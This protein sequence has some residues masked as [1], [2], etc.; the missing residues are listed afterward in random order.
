MGL[1][2]IDKIDVL[3]PIYHGCS[4]QVLSKGAGHLPSSALPI[5]SIGGRSLISAHSGSAMA[6]L[7]T[8][9]DE[10]SIGDWFSIENPLE[11]LDYQVVD[12]EIVTPEQTES[13]MPQEGEDLVTL[14]TCTPYGINSH[15]LLVTGKRG[16]RPEQ[17]QEISLFRSRRFW[18]LVLILTLA[19]FGGIRL[20]QSMKKRKKHES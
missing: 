19:G 18:G 9:L 12:I 20:V 6:E 8:R 7:F 2:S 13:L 1:I 16:I 15:R 3:L 17:H 10:L 14:I 11:R 4:D 5:G